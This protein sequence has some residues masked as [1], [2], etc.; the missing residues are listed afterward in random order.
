MKFLHV[1]RIGENRGARR[2]W[3]EFDF[4]SECG[5]E[6]GQRLTVDTTANT[7]TLQVC[8]DD[9]SRWD[10]TVSRRGDKPLIEIRGEMIPFDNDISKL[11]LEFT[12]KKVVIKPHHSYQYI[13]DRVQRLMHKVRH[14]IPLDAFSLF[15]GAGIFDRALH[16][17]LEAQGVRSR[18][19]VSVERETK[20]LLSSVRNNRHLYD[21]N[22]ILI[23]ASLQ[24]L[25]ISKSGC[26]GDIGLIAIPCTAA[27]IAGRT[28]KKLERPEQ[29]KDAGQLVHY[30][31]K[32]IERANL[33]I[34]LMEC[35]SEYMNTASYDIAT[36]VL[37]ESGYTL[38]DQVLFGNDF[39]AIENRKRMV[40]VAVSNDLVQAF[41]LSEFDQFKESVSYCLSD[42]LDDVDDDNEAWRDHSYLLKKEQTD[43]A[44]GKGFRHV[45]LKGDEKTG[46][47]AGKGYFKRRSNEPFIGRD[48]DELTRL[49]ST[50]EHCRYKTIP[51]DMISGL[52]DS[53]AHEI[54]GQSGIFKKIRAV[55]EWIGLSLMKLSNSLEYS[56]AA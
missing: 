5:F 50:K 8:D 11:R 21:D 19:A 30:Y 3:L 55:F 18:V 48:R 31:L 37:N 47:V 51:V 40:T 35:V 16:D 52:S 54:L 6:P 10:K 24:D 32:W 25:D 41:E 49:L 53:V 9:C 20:Y 43:K 56:I 39:G 36:T 12:S 1:S 34:I 7:L 38:L 44:D 22:S 26:D 2:I 46:P 4:L 33:P 14:G 29:D 42:I 17:G 13:K 23:N 45:I 28:R 15:S 27:S